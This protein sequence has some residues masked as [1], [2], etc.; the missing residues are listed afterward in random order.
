MRS[1]SV[2]GNVTTERLMDV[3]TVT[4]FRAQGMIGNSTI[5]YFS[6]KNDFDLLISR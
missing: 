3:F 2:D 6:R 5:Q 1:V 4:V